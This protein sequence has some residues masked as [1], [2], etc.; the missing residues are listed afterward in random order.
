[1]LVVKTDVR[2][3]EQRRGAWS[4]EYLAEIVDSSDDAIIGKTLDGVII[5][6]N[7]GAERLYGYLADEVVGQ[8]IS[9]LIPADHPDE[10]P[11]IMARLRRGERVDHYR[12]VRLR[13][14]G[15]RVPV[16]VTISPVHDA[17]GRVVGASSIARDVSEQERAVHDALQLREQFIA[18]AAHELRTPLTTVF[19]RLQ[20][21]ERRLKQPD[22]DRQSLARDVSLVRQGADKLRVLLERL[23]DI[24]RIRSGQLELDRKPTDVVTLVRDAAGEFAET[25]G[26][27]VKVSAPESTRALMNVDGVRIEEVVTNLIDNANKYGSANQPIEVDIA[28]DPDA[29]RVAVR[30]HGP[31]IPP[32]QR[33]RI[34]EVFQRASA[35]ARGVGLGL[36]IAREIVLLHGGSL[37]VEEGE[38]GGA[39]FVMTLP[40]GSPPD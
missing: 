25:L 14:D 6:W 30:D 1:L 11:Q 21:A 4:P 26:R 33:G 16:S 5:S 39:R 34:F 7:K 8:P 27:D 19:A 18:I 15:A 10:L 22:Y 40:K 17:D 29:V 38:G 20:L 24:S 2:T 31:G 28:D 37:E 32:D 3:D 23:L 36:H 9:I 12:T 13:K 35:D